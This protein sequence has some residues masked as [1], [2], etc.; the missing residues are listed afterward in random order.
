MLIRSFARLSGV[1]PGFRTDHL[2][3]LE[4]Y[5]PYSR[6]P[7]TAKRAAFYDELLQRVESLASVEA[8][9]V[10][11]VLPAKGDLGHMTYITEQAGTVKVVAACE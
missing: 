11:T 1:D 6:Y 5:P 10:V 3:T 2:L 4:V 7:D 9:G 8:A